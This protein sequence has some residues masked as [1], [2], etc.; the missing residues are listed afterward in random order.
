MILEIHGKD[1]GASVTTETWDYT[2]PAPNQLV[3]QGVH[4]GTHVH[5]TLHLEP[6]PRL[7]TRGFHWVTEVPFIQ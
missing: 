3:I 4:R 7:V 6:I 1:P 2:R 5:V